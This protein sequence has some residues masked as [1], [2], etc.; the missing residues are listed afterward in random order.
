MTFAEVFIERPVTTTLVTLAIALAGILAYFHLPVAPLPQVDFPTISVNASL[1]S[2][3]TMAATVATPLERTLGRIPGVNEMTSTSSQGSTR[4]TLQFDLSRDIDGAANDVQ[5]AI[6]GAR[7]LLPSGLPS[8]PSYRKTNPADAPIMILSLTSDVHTPGQ[9]YDAAST[10]LAQKI[11]QLPGIGQVFVGGSSLPA[12]RVALDLPKL[13]QSGL[14]LEDIRSTLSRANVNRPKGSVEQGDRR[15]Q[16]TANDQLS[17]ARDYLPLI[18]NHRSG[19]FLRLG[20]LGRVED[21]VQDTLNYGTSNGVPSV[22]L[23]IFRQSGA[24]ILSTVEGVKALLPNL[25]GTIPAAMNLNLV[26]ERTVSIKGSLEEVKHSLMLSIALVIG[27]VWIF[28]RRFKAALIP[29]VAVPV[30]LIGTFAVMWFCNYSIDN[31]SLMALT[32]ATG[33]VV[34]DAV[35]VLENITRH[36]E[37]GMPAKEAAKRGAREVTSTVVS[38]SISLVAVFI[39][40]LFMGGIVGRLF[41]EFAVVLS[42]SIAISLLISL[43]ATPTMCARLLA[44]HQGE[45]PPNRFAR[46]IGLL[47]ARLNRG[48][49]RSLAVAL[50]HRWLVLA[51]LLGTIAFTARLYVVAPKG[52]FPQQDTG[53]LRGSING[54]QG[55]SFQAMKEKVAAIAEII[56]QDSAVSSVNASTGGDARNSGNVFVSLKRK[57]ERKETAEQVIARLRGK[58]SQIPG[59]TLFLSP[60][61]DIRIGGRPSATAYQYTLQSDN[62]DELRSWEPAVRQALQKIPQLTDV[63]SD[64]QDKGGLIRLKIDRDAASRL[65]VSVA[66]IDT[67]LNSAFGQRQV[68]IIHGELNQY[69]VVLEADP[70]QRQDASALQLIRVKSQSGELVPLT[71]VA[72]W[73]AAPAPLTVNHQ[74]QFAAIT[75][76]FNVQP[77]VAF[78]EASAAIRDAMHQIGLPETVQRAFTGSAGMFQA[79]L[80]NQPWLILTALLVIYLTLGVLYESFLHPLTI[81]STLPSAGVGALLALLLCRLP[82]DIMGSIGIFLLI[83]IVKKNAIMMIDFALDAERA[84]RLSPRDAILEA[85]DKRLR[86]ILMTTVAAMLGALP[87]AIGFGEGSE[88]RRPLGVAIVG[89]LF[90]SQILTLYTTPVVYLFLDQLRHRFLKRK[91]A[92]LV[93]TPLTTDH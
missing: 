69:R 74:G 70:A 22:S 88:L 60:T 14:S 1:A 17:H 13:E 15:W 11:S 42:V 2:P 30:S 83:G 93:S 57:P 55:I 54:D 89:G 45:R 5:A 92:L 91:P 18:V 27:V 68:S 9:L 25:T 34:D 36:I 21:S 46:G 58:T 32:I 44:H 76:S 52:L 29:G 61:Q 31:L 72:T 49:T 65:G 7:S 59:A 84:R 6:N 16:I 12:V 63:N 56:R 40:I 62:L 39:P 75:L 78:G 79:S 47:F 73:D 20:D 8:N 28:L 26:M 19:A 50:D 87:L 64:F 35:V 51:I 81:L 33:F 43:T 37:S 86:P 71:A 48:Y 85:C 67:T 53:Q 82:F 90:F 77:G 41:R 66:E 4:I 80:R 38:M 24:N 10:I 23:V 3:E